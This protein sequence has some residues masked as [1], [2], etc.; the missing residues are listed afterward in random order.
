I[1]GPK[2]GGVW[3]PGVSIVGATGPAGANGKSAF[4]IWQSLPG[5]S[6]KTI[7]EYFNSIT[8][9]AGADGKTILNGTGAPSGTTGKDGDF[10]IDPT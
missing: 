3:P 6:S 9:P 2:T 5:N 10:Y 4:E 1:Y 8:G 7:T